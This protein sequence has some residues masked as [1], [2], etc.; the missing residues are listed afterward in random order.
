M[1]FQFMARLQRWGKNRI[2]ENTKPS[3]L[4]REDEDKH[5]VLTGP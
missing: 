3:Q 2:A 5:S 1:V 4:K